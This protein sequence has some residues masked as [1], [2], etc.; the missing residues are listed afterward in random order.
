MGVS[1]AGRNSRS[2]RRSTMLLRGSFAGLAGCWLALHAGATRGEPAG[3]PGSASELPAP[4]LP[5]PPENAIAFPASNLPDPNLPD[6]TLPDPPDDDRPSDSGFIENL[7]D[8]PLALQFRRAWGTTWSETHTL[9]P[10]QRLEIGRSKAPDWYGLGDHVV[11]QFVVVRY[12][13]LNGVMR[14]RL[15]ARS[16]FDMAARLP[17]FYFIVDS[18]GV[19]RMIN[20]PT[21][22]RARQIQQQLL[23]QPARS[24]EELRQYR[25]QL[26][27]AGMWQ[28]PPTADTPDRAVV[29]EGNSGNPWQADMAWDSTWAGAWA[30]RGPMLPARRTR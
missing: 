11:P 7:S 10:G 27:R 23:A 26:A 6:E 16:S 24:P 29:I 17:Y 1:W 9:P 18:S 8:A 25:D 22:E 14:T 12:P 20:A 5:A 13:A 4:T 30:G 2:A 15:S 21:I 28:P 3:P 19:G